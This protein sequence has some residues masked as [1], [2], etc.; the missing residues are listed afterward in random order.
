[1]CIVLINFRIKKLPLDNY[2]NNTFLRYCILKKNFNRY[3]DYKT[4][5]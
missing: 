5:T 4:L 3:N 2:L 1:M